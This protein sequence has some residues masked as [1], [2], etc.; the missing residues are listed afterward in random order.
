[1]N[2]HKSPPLAHDSLTIFRSPSPTLDYF[3]QTISSITRQADPKAQLLERWRNIA[4]YIA[5]TRISWDCVIALNRNL[6][7]VENIL[8]SRAPI[9][10]GWKA[11]KEGFGLGISSMAD[12]QSDVRYMNEITPPATDAPRVVGEA[13]DEKQGFQNNEALLGRVTKAVAQL[14]ERHHEFKVGRMWSA[15]IDSD[16]CQLTPCD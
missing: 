16:S 8:R 13:N 2:T 5:S 1:M 4:D 12:S 15:W 7:T 10:E 11:S 3:A 14:R 9:D 6:D